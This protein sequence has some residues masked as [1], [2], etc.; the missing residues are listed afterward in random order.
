VIVSLSSAFTPAI[1]ENKRQ[2]R[3]IAGKNTRWHFE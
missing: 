2:L 3:E 1:E